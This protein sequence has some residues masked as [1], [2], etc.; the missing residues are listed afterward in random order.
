MAT[1]AAASAA[2]ADVAAALALA[3]SGDIVTVPAGTATWSTAFNVAAG[4]TLAGAG[5]DTIITC[6]VAS[7]LGTVRL[8]SGSTLKDFRMIGGANPCFGV[9]PGAT[10][11]RISGITYTSTAANSY[12]LQLSS[13]YGLIDQCDITGPGDTS[14]LI[15]TKGESD[16]WDN[17]A[18]YGTDQAVYIEDCTF[19]GKGYVSDFNSNAKGVVRSCVITGQIKVDLHGVASNSLPSRS[20]RHMEVY[21]CSWSAAGVYRAIEHRGGGLIAFNNYNSATGT[22]GSLRLHDYAFNTAFWTNFDTMQTPNDYPIRDQI[23]RGRYTTPGDWTT[24]E[25]EPCYLWGNRRLTA[26]WT[27]SFDTASTV[28]SST[29]TTTGTTYPV[30][31]TQIQLSGTGKYGTGTSFKITGDTTRYVVTVGRPSGSSGLITISPPLAQEIV[32]VATLTHGAQ[33]NYKYQQMNESA[34]FTPQ[35]V[36]LADRDYFDEVAA[37][38]GASGVGIGTRAQMDAI[39]P[40]LAG[41]G[42]WV[43]DEG[44]WN[45]L[46]AANTSGRLYTWSGSAWVFKY[47]PYTYPHPLRGALAA[48]TISV[49]PTNKTTEEGQPTIFSLAASGNPSLTF[50]WRKGGVAI[51]GATSTSY[52]ISN[53]QTTDAGT[54][55][56]VVTNSQGSVTSSSVTLT[57][58]PFEAGALPVI[59]LQP[60]GVTT[61]AEEDVTFTIAATGDPTPTYQWRKNGVAISGETGTTLFLAIVS[62]SDEATYSC[63]VSNQGGSVLSDV[64]NLTV[65]PIPPPAPSGLGNPTKHTSRA[66]LV[67]ISL[68]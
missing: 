14:E 17:A 46:L 40:T 41:V 6:S 2:Y 39:I 57:V 10:G 30:G 65:D 54:F 37:F 11:W 23:G 43:T 42:F 28:A 22:S 8:F 12:F 38:T 27:I 44:S 60:V 45:T 49:Q 19:R 36:I 20:G 66:S 31:T 16:A 51:S 3:T 48:P 15:F 13:G 34:S 50:Q 62:E 59:T 67:G 4:V 63:T 26:K 32:G 64:V 18:T 52:T 61:Y 5:V 55:D 33:Q 29:R 68:V 53:T 25:S 7:S 9:S 35:Q 58:N 47:E 24:A 56:C 1:Y 21:E